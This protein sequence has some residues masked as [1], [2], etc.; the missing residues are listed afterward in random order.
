MELKGRLKLIADKVPLCDTVCDVGTDHAYI[1]IYLISNKICKKAVATD[2]KKGPILIAGRNIK[3]S[4]L[5]GFI[6]TRLGDGLD[7]LKEAEVDVIIV[8]GMG[9]L[10]IQEILEKGFKKAQKANKLVL[11]PMNAIEVLRRWLY[12]NKFDIEDEQLVD[13]GEKI[14]NVIVAR[15]TE[16]KR[17][18]EE[19]HYYI[20]EKLIARNDPL[21]GRYLRKRVR[22]LDNIIHEMRNSKGDNNRV[23]QEYMWLRQKMLDILAEVD[24]RQNL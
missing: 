3:E 13:E 15:W 6:E 17:N 16:N 7:P 1:P 10:L 23:K 5:E 14:Y 9:G 22:Q 21:L 19:I 2:V 8:A 4:G 18:P 24:T 20:G 11:Q 12:D